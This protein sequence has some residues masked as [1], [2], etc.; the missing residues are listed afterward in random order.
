MKKNNKIIRKKPIPQ[1][2]AGQVY[3]DPRYEPAFKELFDSEDALKDFLDGVLGLEGDDKIRTIKFVFDKSIRFRVPQSKKIIFDVFITT[4]SGRYLDVEMQK[5]D[6]DFLVDRIVLYNAFLV[7]KGKKE[8]E[9][10]EEFLALSKEKKKR[11]VMNFLRPY[12][13]G[14]AILSCLMQRGNTK[15]NG[16]FTAS[17]P[18]EMEGLYPSFLKIDIFSLVCPISRRR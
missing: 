11:S 2:F 18:S 7:I 5:L 15:M 17:V 9:R 3:L 16:P 4:N 1:S 8:M 12:L 6:H 13:F 14:Y 10:S